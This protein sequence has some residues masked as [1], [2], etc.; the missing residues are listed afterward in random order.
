MKKLLKSL[1]KDLGT[2]TCREIPRIDGFSSL[3]R[4]KVQAV[5]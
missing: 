3:V 2:G 1:E 4:T 5:K